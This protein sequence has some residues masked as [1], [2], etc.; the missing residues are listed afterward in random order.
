MASQETDLSVTLQTT[1]HKRLIAMKTELHGRRTMGAG[2]VEFP[3]VD[4]DEYF[5]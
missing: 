4:H 2:E 3:L 1:E 5:E